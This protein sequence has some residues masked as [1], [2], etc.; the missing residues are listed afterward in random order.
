M[1]KILSKRL[2]QVFPKLIDVNQFT[3]LGGRNMLDSVLV[4][5][6]AVD[7]A[8]KKKKPTIV[9]KVDYE[10]AYDSVRWDFLLYM[11][12]RMNFCDKW[13]NWISG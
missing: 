4:V 5:N 13:I 7:E 6:E 3:F 12:R 1:S 10:K 11:L 2:K 8:K 9:F